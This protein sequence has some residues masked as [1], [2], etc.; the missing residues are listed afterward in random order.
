[1][2]KEPESGFCARFLGGF[3][4]EFKGERIIITKNMKQKSMQIL[5]ILLK[6][7]REGVTRRDLIGMLEWGGD[8]WEKKLNNLRR[9]TCN[10]RK[11]INEAGFPEGEYIQAKKGRY[12]FSFEYDVETDTGKIDQLYHEARRKAGGEAREGFLWE[13]CRLYQGEFLPF[14]VAEE[15]A[16]VEN[17]HYRSIYSRCVNEL[18][19]ALKERGNY[20]E[21]LQLC[22]EASRIHPYDEW[23]AVQIDCLVASN[24]PQDARKVRRQANELFVRDLGIA[25]FHGQTGGKEGLWADIEP[26]MGAMGE[27]MGSLLETNT[28]KGAYQCSCPQFTDV[29]RFMV[30]MSGRGQVKLGLLL[31]TLEP[32]GAEAGA[33]GELESR[34]DPMGGKAPEEGAGQKA[35]GF[36]PIPEEKMERFGKLLA[37]TL[38]SHDVYTRYSQNQYLA[39]LSGF[40][41]SQWTEAKGRFLQ[42]WKAFGMEEQIRVETEIQAVG[43]PSR[44]EAI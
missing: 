6:A 43:E 38:R 26:D 39:L 23:Q 30:R 29:Y 5:L 33:A 21:L 20:G 2:P 9:Q 41:E 13:I 14:L 34:A 7:G 8:S 44:K 24:Q 22:T 37:A 28:P 42:A 12:Y 3:F 32:I 36:Q 16:L 1:M 17:A 40:G 11:A 31:C 10:L 15:W 4:L 25:P 19:R 18:C 35:T 27:V